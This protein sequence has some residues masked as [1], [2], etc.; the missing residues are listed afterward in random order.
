MADDPIDL[1]S[2]AAQRE[3]QLQL[4]LRPLRG[5]HRQFAR[6][7]PNPHQVAVRRQQ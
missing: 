7:K 1:V 4:Q 2:E 5:P 3:A 6:S